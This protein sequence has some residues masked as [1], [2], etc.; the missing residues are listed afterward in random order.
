M[1]GSFPSPLMGEGRVRVDD[2]GLV[3]ETGMTIMVSSTSLAMPIA[4]TR[5]QLPPH[6]SPLPRKARAR[7]IVEFCTHTRSGRAK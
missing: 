7:D 5:C 3:R 1:G 4:S 6:P 2:P